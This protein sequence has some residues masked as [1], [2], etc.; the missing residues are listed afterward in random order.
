[1]RDERDKKRDSKKFEKILLKDIIIKRPVSDISGGISQN[2]FHIRKL[3][4]KYLGKKCLSKTLGNKS[5]L[6]VMIGMVTMI[7]NGQAG[8]G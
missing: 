2:V 3:G 1:M 6:Q 7:V 4:N 5:F 8:P